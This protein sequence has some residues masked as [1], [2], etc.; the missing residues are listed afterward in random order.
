MLCLRYVSNTSLPALYGETILPFQGIISKV[1][2]YLG[3]VL[4]EK[5]RLYFGHDQGLTYIPYFQVHSSRLKVIYH[6]SELLK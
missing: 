3:R 1:N 4:Y 6:V 2:L 5:K